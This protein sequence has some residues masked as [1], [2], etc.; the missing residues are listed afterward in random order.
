MAESNEDVDVSSKNYGCFCFKKILFKTR[1][2][3]KKKKRSPHLEGTI[4][5]TRILFFGLRINSKL[6]GLKLQYLPLIKVCISYVVLN[7]TSYILKS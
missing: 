5:P 4:Y 2:K 1:T 7:T 6:L 3:K